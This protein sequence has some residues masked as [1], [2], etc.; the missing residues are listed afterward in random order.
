MLLPQGGA[1]HTAK[2]QEKALVETSDGGF[3]VAAV[4]GNDF[5][6][7]KTDA[8]GNAE[9]NQ[10]YGGPESE[11]VKTLVTT[12]DG[13]FA[14]LGYFTDG[15]GNCDCLLVKTDAYGNMQWNQTYGRRSDLVNSLVETSDGGYA[16]AGSFSSDR[17]DPF[18][19]RDF[20]LIKTDSYG[21][22]EWTQTYGGSGYD[23]AN[24][25]IETFDGG[26][27]LA[28]NTGLYLVQ[29]NILIIK[30]DIQGNMEWNQTYQ[31]RELSGANSLV[32]TIDGG[33]A[34]AGYLSHDFW[35]IKIDQTGNPEWNQT[36]SKS[37]DAEAYSLV[38]TS[39]GGYTLAGTISSYVGQQADIDSWIIKTDASGN[40]MWNQTY[41]GSENQ[42]LY[43]LVETS[44]KGLV[45][46]GFQ[47]S[48]HNGSTE[49]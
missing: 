47:T 46:A 25:L 13:G 39:D 6:L 35:L 19:D 28:G 2:E 12:S 15:Y 38:I 4:T 24:A 16:I 7:I 18:G 33:Y 8:H 34:I 1:K 32:K 23:G 29:S 49:V 11:T 27:L 26:Y 30:T 22:I 45:L 5:W 31:R 44:N 40:I 42:H 10:T 37:E 36:Y 17:D 3:A 9:W 48:K 43:A 14:I 41:G 21:N 20:W